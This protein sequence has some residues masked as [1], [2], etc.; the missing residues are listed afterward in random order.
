MK[1]FSSRLLDAS[2]EQKV[3]LYLNE[4]I[5]IAIKRSNTARNLFSFISDF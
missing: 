5:G 1:T 2:G 4:R 3:G